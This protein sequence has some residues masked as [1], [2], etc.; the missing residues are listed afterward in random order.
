MS[1]AGA[2]LERV[3]PRVIWRRR[4][5]TWKFETGESEVRLLPLLVDRARAAIDVGAADGAYTVALIQLAARVVA[6]E[7]IPAK[8]KLLRG[9][10]TRT[11]FV[12]VHEVALSDCHGEV[13]LRIPH[14]FPW[15]STVELSNKLEG[16]NEI[17]KVVVKRE[18]LDSFGITDVGFMK[19]DVEGHEFATLL[20]AT[21]TIARD[22]PNILVEIEERH[23]PGAI[24]SVQHL[25]EQAG[26][27]G[28]FLL[29][30]QLKPLSEFDQASHQDRS[31]LDNDGR[32]TGVYVNNFIFVPK[33]I[34]H[35]F[36]GSH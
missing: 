18:T 21:K 33:E 11:K 34:F 1:L 25:L 13:T 15:R 26:Y 28:C 19:I 10:F 7:P 6:F 32:P 5:R 4:I 30:G 29:E 3:M 16:R 24:C 17:D 31:R 36:R 2:F 23:R 8:A 35:Q 14:D 22:R 12:T 9:L 27:Q 20:G